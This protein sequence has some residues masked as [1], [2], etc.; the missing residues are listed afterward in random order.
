MGA[1]AD[2]YDRQPPWSVL[3]PQPLTTAGLTSPFLPSLASRQH[4]GLAEA[5]G[6]GA[7]P[8]V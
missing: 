6:H 4:G 3:V 2:P 1:A 8:V 7:K 5:V